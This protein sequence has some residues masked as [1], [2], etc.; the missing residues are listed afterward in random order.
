MKIILKDL[1]NH[2][3]INDF[4]SISADFDKLTEEIGRVG[5]V[6]LEKGKD[7]I[8]PTYVL[9]SFIKIEDAINNV[10]NE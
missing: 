5:N 4:V 6:V 7:D 2:L 10:T 9:R 8:L 1:N 3:K